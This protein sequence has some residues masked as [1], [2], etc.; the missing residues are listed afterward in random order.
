VYCPGKTADTTRVSQQLGAHSSVVIRPAAII[1]EAAAHAILAALRAQ[2][3]SQGGVW[4]ATSSI[5]QRYDR[6][7]DGDGGTRGNAELLGTICVSYDTPSRYLITI[8]RAAVTDHA[9][10]HGWTVARLCDDALQYGGL[11]L[12]SCPRAE[13]VA[14]PVP[15]PFHAA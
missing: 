2:D 5:W 6:D 11:S 12:D 14:P 10:E 13:L 3:V 1:P 8:Y 7:F 4:N 15:D 9:A